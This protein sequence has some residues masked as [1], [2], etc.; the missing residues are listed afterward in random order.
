MSTLEERVDVGVPIDKA[1]DDLHRVENYPRF[2]EGVREVR[3]EAGGRARVDVEVGGRARE[4]E[5]EISDRK[6]ERVMEWH[7]TGDPELA[8]SFSLQ[9]IDQNSTR[10][11]ARL[12]YDPDTIRETFGGLKGFAQANAIERLV[13]GDLEH[14]KECVEQGR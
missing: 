10:V 4:F 5:A 9:P 12:E 6:G 14:F 13:R 8:G 1:W 7:T 11:Q 2:V 3:T